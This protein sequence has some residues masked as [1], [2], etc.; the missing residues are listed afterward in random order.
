MIYL[1]I[2]YTGFL[3]GELV[4]RARSRALCVSAPYVINESPRQYTY[5]NINACERCSRRLN[6]HPRNILVCKSRVL[7]SKCIEVVWHSL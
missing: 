6:P 3:V 5:M 4:T 7:I 1:P 2:L